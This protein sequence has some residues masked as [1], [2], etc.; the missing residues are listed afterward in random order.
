ME[1]LTF[2]DREC[3][4]YERK[5]ITDTQLIDKLGQYEDLDEQ[6]A[7]ENSWNLIMLLRKWKEFVGDIQELYE[8]RK[9]EE[10]GKLLKLPCKV[11]DTVYAVQTIKRKEII[12][13]EIWDYTV[14]SLH[15]ERDCDWNISFEHIEPNGRIFPA[16]G[17]FKD[18]GETVFFT[19]SEAENALQK[20][21]EMEEKE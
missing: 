3:V 19:K 12:T 2:K 14:I 9:L 16:Y 11:G 21:N 18:I 1:R 4:H 15:I 7:N 8:Y 13:K 6:C 10:Q 17:Q 20:M 5:R